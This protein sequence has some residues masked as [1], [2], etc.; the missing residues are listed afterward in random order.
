MQD[1][2]CL[3]SYFLGNNNSI[4]IVKANSAN[5]LVVAGDDNLWIFNF[6]ING[7]LQL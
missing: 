5:K 3:K 2:D 1:E 4:H 6:T 7:D